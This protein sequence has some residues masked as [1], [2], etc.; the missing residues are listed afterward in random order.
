MPTADS[1]PSTVSPPVTAPSERALLRALAR[2][3]REAGSQL[4][5]RTYRQVWTTQMRF[6]HGDADLAS[7][8]TQE[9]YRRAWAAIASFDGR[10][11]FATWL[12]RIA[13]TT[14]LNH[15]RR[16]R[17]VVP[18]EDEVASVVASGA[19]D[20]ETAVLRSEQGERMRRAVLSLPET[21]RDT[22]AARF[23]GGLP[24]REIAASEGL[25]EV[26]IRK[27]LRKAY[28]LLQTALEVTS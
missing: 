28:G 20:S 3:D 5:E 17:R 25:S 16:P 13:Y 2:G 26:A 15:L 6:T 23:W 8:L 1:L 19:E 4:V 9:T 12:Y 24:V 7:D 22:V 18:L 14:F 10:A 11:A 21:L 27:R